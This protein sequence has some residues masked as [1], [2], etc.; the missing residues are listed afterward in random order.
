MLLSDTLSA[1]AKAIQANSSRSFLTMLGIIIGTGSVVMMVSLGNTFQQYILQQVESFGKNTLDIIPKGF[2]KF[3][4][5]LD[6]ISMDDFDAVRSLS[7]IEGA[8]P[9]I[10]VSKSIQYDDT[11]I[12]PMTLGSYHSLFENYGLTIDRGRMLTKNDEEGAKS[13]IVIGST[14]AE[15]LFGNNDPI[16]K[17]ISIGES[18]FMVVGVLKKLG[19][20]LAQDFD[21]IVVMPFS[22]ARSLTGQKYLSYITLRTIGDPEVGR[23]DIISVLRDRHNI[24][25]P[26]NDPDKDDFIARSSEQVTQVIGGVT[27]GLTIFLSLIAAISLLVGG[28]GIMNIM[29][30]SVTERTREIGL[31]KALG[32]TKRDILLQF[33]LEAL[34]LTA[35]GGL[36]GLLGGLF[37]GW[38]L[39]QLAGKFLG[40]IS[41]SISVSAIVLALGMAFGSGLI[42]G[43]YPARKAANLSPMEA[44]RYE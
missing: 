10:I 22:V 4:G 2:E 24:K 15:D 34:S 26:E 9:V 35:I 40:T 27:T 29:L 14:T 11:N 30:V 12:S 43:L 36:I 1:S 31:R 41:F 5:N 33:L 37:F 19:S 44:L 8:S 21:K 13:V 18:S 17:R 25:N 6:T 42:F 20:F 3:G 39:T 38:F 7:T 32:A 23:Q 28:I 16:G